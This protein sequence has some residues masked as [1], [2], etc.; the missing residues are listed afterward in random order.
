MK[1]NPRNRG[2]GVREAHNHAKVGHRSREYQIWVGMISRCYNEKHTSYRDYGGRG[3]TVCERWLDSF[4]LFL[5]DMGKCPSTQHTLDRRKNNLGYFKKNCRWVTQKVQG[6]NRRD[7]VLITAN[8]E[9]LVL[10]EWAE[11]LGVSGNALRLRK[12]KGWSDSDVIN[13]P[14]KVRLTPKS[15]LNVYRDGISGKMTLSAVA[16]R[17]KLPFSTVQ[18]ITSGRNW[19]SVTRAPSG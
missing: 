19:S 4:T 16:S 3:I 6:R 17:Y 7:N 18:A 13:I 14:V 2:Q 11:R 15:V 5:A 10:T 8:G 12:Y 9:T 1:P